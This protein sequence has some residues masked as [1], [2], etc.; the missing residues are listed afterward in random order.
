MKFLVAIS[1]YGH[2]NGPQQSEQFNNEKCN[3]LTL[4]TGVGGEP[5]VRN[6][7]TCCDWCWC[8][9]F[10]F[11]RRN[12]IGC[13]HQLE[14]DGAA[15]ALWMGQEDGLG[16]ADRSEVYGSWPLSL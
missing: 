12:L 5:Q 2:G 11:L 16:F 9:S 14:R 15:V 4:S 3:T 6:V 7:R 8:W 13:P 1:A 10:S